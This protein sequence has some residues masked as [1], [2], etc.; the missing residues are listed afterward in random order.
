MKTT[1]TCVE[2]ATNTTQLVELWRVKRDDADYD[3]HDGAVI[4]AE[5][6]NQL[7]VHV[8]A[9]GLDTLLTS[10]TYLGIADG[11]VKPGVVLTSYIGG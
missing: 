9:L 4:A 5:N 2:A 6:R 8:R 3:Q 10:Y 1:S 7:M 11:S